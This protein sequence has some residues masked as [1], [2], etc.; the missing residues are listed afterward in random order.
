[1]ELAENRHPR[2]NGKFQ[3]VYQ[4]KASTLE[5]LSLKQRELRSFQMIHRIEGKELLHIILDAVHNFH[6]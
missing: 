5:A 1:M 3:I 6:A 4:S 2:G